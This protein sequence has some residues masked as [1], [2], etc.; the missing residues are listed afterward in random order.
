MYQEFKHV[1]FHCKGVVTQG[2]KKELWVRTFNPKGFK[3]KDL[4]ATKKVNARAG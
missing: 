3:D 2:T 4:G 1:Q